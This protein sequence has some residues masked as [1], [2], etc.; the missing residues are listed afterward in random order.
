[1]FAL[2]AKTCKFAILCDPPIWDFDNFGLKSALGPSKR[3]K[4]DKIKSAS[5]FKL[6]LEKVSFW[7]FSAVLS[8]WGPRGAFVAKIRCKNRVAE[9]SRIFFLK[10]VT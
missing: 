1:M 2:V 5:F 3:S 6:D 4:F 7:V 8:L 9:V 10:L